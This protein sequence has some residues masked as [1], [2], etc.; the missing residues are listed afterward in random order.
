[1]AKVEAVSA[2]VSIA[3]AVVALDVAFAKSQVEAV[4]AEVAKP[5][6]AVT[7]AITVVVLAKIA[8]LD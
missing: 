4:S 6:E 5:A 2:E 7:A 3:A 1:M 8:I